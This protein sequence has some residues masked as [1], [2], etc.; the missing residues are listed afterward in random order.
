[1]KKI[2]VP[3]SILVFI[4]PLVSGCGSLAVTYR[5]PPGEAESGDHDAPPVYASLEIPEGHLPPPGS[6][7]IWFPG[8][9]PGHQPPPGACEQ[10]ARDIPP[11]AWLL[12]RP[13]EQPHYVDVSV[14]DERRPGVVVEI[15]IFDAET[16]TFVGIRGESS[17]Q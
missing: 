7:G 16:G 8:T 14:Y 15:R 1:M 17:R 5:H 6:C 4:L 9:P 10:L 3:F 11:G 12:Y 2:L 13:S